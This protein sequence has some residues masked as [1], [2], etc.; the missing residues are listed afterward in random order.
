MEA[1]TNRDSTQT[2]GAKFVIERDVLQSVIGGLANRGYRVIGPTVRDG[3]IVY[4]T[5]A[6][7]DDLPVGWTD[8]QDAG[9][10]RIE[11][12]GDPA[13]FGYAVGPFLEVLFAPPNRAALR[14]RR[15][16]PAKLAD[17]IDQFG[18]SGCVGCGRCIAWCPVGIDITEES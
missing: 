13:L 4:D 3:A 9:R 17:W 7:L 10:C 14:A 12:R 11:R 1:R 6:Q 16:A 15:E 8:R 2:L 18:T 5:L